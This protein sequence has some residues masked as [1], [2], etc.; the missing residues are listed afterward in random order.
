M[1]AADPLDAISPQCEPGCAWRDLRPSGREFLAGLP[2]A[3]DAS[4][5]VVIALRMID[6]LDAQVRELEREL[7]K[8]AGR[9]MRPRSP[10]RACKPRL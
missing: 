6:T 5:R 3:L 9:S 8:I 7:R 1:A 2:L 10:R 4:E